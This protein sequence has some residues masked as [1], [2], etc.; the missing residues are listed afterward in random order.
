MREPYA[1]EHG[2]SVTRKAN[3]N[4]TMPGFAGLLRWFVCAW[5]AEMPDR[6][7][8]GGVWHDRR[9]SGDPE[10]YQ[11]VGGSLIG[12]PQDAAPFVSVVYGSAFRLEHPE[13]EGRPEVGTSYASP[14]RATV[15]YLERSRH[16]LL[17]RWLRAL[18]RAGG[19][20]QTVTAACG[21]P[22]EY[23]ESITRDAL[24]LAWKAYQDTPYQRGT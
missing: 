4:G 2:A 22:D 24:R 18:G 13:S 20:W 11:P 21:L 14:M 1:A 19:D 9:M 8:A 3:G 12:S 7:H 23:G 10:G 16:P 5:A 17:A 15:T 6:I